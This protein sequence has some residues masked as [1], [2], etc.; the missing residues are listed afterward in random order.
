MSDTM[1]R[2]D[3]VNIVFGKKPAEALALMD[4]GLSRAEIQ[5]RTGQVLGVH[6]C[7]LDVRNGE[8]LVLMGLSD[9]GKSTLLRA[10]NGLNP[11]VRGRV[12]VN[13][14]DGMVDVVGASPREL[15]KLRTE[16]VAMVFQQFGL[17]LMGWRWRA[18]LRPDAMPAHARNSTWCICQNGQI[19]RLMNCP[20][21]CSNASDLRA[22][23]QPTP[24]SC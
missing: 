19:A 7:S 23:S 13:S 4:D 10:V 24:R 8:I 18:L 5:E 6:N 16:R 21:A 20:G 14:G 9:S 22:P 2:F 3:N 1:V 15:R 12:K 17:W 11:V